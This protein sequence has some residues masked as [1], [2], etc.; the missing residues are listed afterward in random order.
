[1]RKFI[2]LLLVFYSVNL[3]AQSYDSPVDYN[4]EN[5][6]VY[7]FDITVRK[8]QDPDTKMP[9]Y[10]VFRKGK[11]IRY[12][13]AVD[14]DRYLW[15]GLSAGTRIAVGPFNTHDQAVRANA[16]YDLSNAS[17]DSTLLADNNVYHWY[18]VT[19]KQSKRLK[20]YQFERIP[21]RIVSGT[22]KDFLDLMKVSL[23]VNKLVIG[24]FE[25]IPEA[26]NSKRVFR[27]EE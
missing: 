8:L 4:D 10:K 23:S 22:Y 11:N 20:S 27:L 6:R 17:K 16:L 3:F 5:R 9:L 15:D 13:S 24:V 21:A 26:E 14:Y 12:G 7:W 1:M 18:I 2:V 19:L 25:D